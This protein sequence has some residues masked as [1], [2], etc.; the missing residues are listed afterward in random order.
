MFL[1]LFYNH[2]PFWARRVVPPLV[3]G[4]IRIGGNVADWS[5][6]QAFMTMTSARARLYGL[7]SSLRG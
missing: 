2:K 5:T 3:R 4:N 7:I 1:F 6:T